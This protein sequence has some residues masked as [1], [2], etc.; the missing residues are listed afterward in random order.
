MYEFTDLRGALFKPTDAEYHEAEAK[1]AA[2]N[3]DEVKVYIVEAL[4]TVFGKERP[5]NF[6][7]EE[8]DDREGE[9]TRALVL[10]G[11]YI[12]PTLC[13]LQRKTIAP[14]PPELILGWA[15]D[16]GVQTGGTHWEPPDFDFNEIGLYQTLH[17]VACAVVRNCVDEALD[18]FGEMMQER[19]EEKMLASLTEDEKKMMGY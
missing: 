10:D 15:L 18:H 16:V 6:L 5:Y 12:Y 14:R 17:Q 8:M 19:D 11:F 2:I 1:R 7:L 4:H 9:P 3:Y 13:A